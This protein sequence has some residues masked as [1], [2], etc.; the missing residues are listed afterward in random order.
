MERK[1]SRVSNDHWN[2]SWIAFVDNLSRRITRHALRE[3]FSFHGK[4]ERVFIPVKNG[5]TKYKVS[6]FMFVSLAS[7]E[8]LEKV[9]V[10][11]DKSRIDG[12][13]VRVSK[14]RF[15]RPNQ[16]G[17]R[18]NGLKAGVGMSFGRVY[19][20][21][22]EVRGLR[23]GEVCGGKTYR[24]ALL[25]SP[26]RVGERNHVPSRECRKSE[27][28]RNN[29]MEFNVSIKETEWL[30]CCMVG[31]LKKSFERDFVE[32]TLNDDIEVKLSKRGGALG[33]RWG[34]FV[35]VDEITAKI[36]RLNDA[37][38]IVRTA[39]LWNIP[40]KNTVSSMG[41]LFRIRIKI[42]TWVEENFGPSH[43]DGGTNFADA[44]A[45]DRRRGA[46]NLVGSPRSLVNVVIP[47]MGINCG[48]NSD[49][50]WENERG[51]LGNDEV[52]L[53]DSWADSEEGEKQ[54]FLCPTSRR[55]RLRSLMGDGPCHIIDLVPREAVT[56]GLE[57]GKQSCVKEV[58]PPEVNNMLIHQTV[59][60][61]SSCGCGF[62]DDSTKVVLDSFEGLEVLHPS[63]RVYQNPPIRAH[64][65]KSLFRASVRRQIR[66]VVRDSLEVESASPGAAVPFVHTELVNSGVEFEVESVWEISNILEVTFKGGREVVVRRVSELENDLR[67]GF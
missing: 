44:D 19:G 36:G 56:K 52:A 34:T 6:M 4:V 7:K 33:N 57:V 3:L 49:W 5:K 11:I 20:G 46:V 38:I 60:A 47:N 2:G 9:I 26:P 65:P 53:V 27:G 8:D 45:P 22:Q 43:V 61:S 10:K 37:R 25:T 41:V 39:S 48:N 31:V 24:E 32:Q 40:E 14:A 64:H 13:V 62:L 30:N 66:Q 54:G 28:C 35:C 59:S 50:R 16:E 51:C 1:E 55:E 17:G 18:T 58:G 12:L 21:I 29:L 23:N 67:N 42:G 63:D 15:P